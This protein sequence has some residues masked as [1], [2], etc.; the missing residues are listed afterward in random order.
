MIRFNHLIIISIYLVSIIYYKHYSLKEG[1]S[2]L[3]S[4]NDM[5][6]SKHRKSKN[7]II[8][9][10]IQISDETHITFIILIS[11]FSLSNEL[12]SAINL[13]KLNVFI[14]KD[15]QKIFRFICTIM[16]SSSSTAL[17]LV[18][19]MVPK[20]CFIFIRN[21]KKIFYHNKDFWL[22]TMILFKFILHFSPSSYL[23]SL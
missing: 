10:S 16:C 12:N 9:L 6:Q 1:G 8:H 13:K 23:V 18:I 11:M 20:C 5:C 21:Y 7:E 14:A 4:L 2:W 3:A 22:N 17:I 19:L 15:V